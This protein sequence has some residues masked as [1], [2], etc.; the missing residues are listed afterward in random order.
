MYIWQLKHIAKELKIKRGSRMNKP[1]LIKELE[2]YTDADINK[3]IPKDTINNKYYCIHGKIKY[4]C[5]ECGGSQICEHNK[6]KYR[7]KKCA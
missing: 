6:S 3:L 7:C 2:K 5:K 1:D 4:C